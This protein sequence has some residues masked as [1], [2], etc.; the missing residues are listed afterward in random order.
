MTAV[1]WIRFMK[2]ENSLSQRIYNLV[3]SSWG[4]KQRYS[5]SLCY[6]SQERITASK[7][8][9]TDVDRQGSGLIC[10][11]F[12]HTYYPVHHCTIAL[13]MRRWTLCPLS[14]RIDSTKCIS[15]T[16]E[17]TLQVKIKNR[18]GHLSKVIPMLYKQNIVVY[19]VYISQCIF[20]GKFHGIDLHS[21]CR[22]QGPILTHIG[23]QKEHKRLCGPNKLVVH[24]H[25][26]QKMELKL[27]CL[28]LKS[29]SLL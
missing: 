25:N 10:H 7:S 15:Q 29:Q 2:Q 12:K 17:F 23:C 21:R 16:T 13:N 20:T 18:K 14:F 24:L 6:S 5:G 19:L 27:Q 1:H 9:V 26:G 8:K 22:V 28:E 4:A 3:F 11:I